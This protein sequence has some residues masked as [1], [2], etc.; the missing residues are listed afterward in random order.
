MSKRRTKFPS[1]AGPLLLAVEAFSLL[2]YL[3]LGC[4]FLC[5]P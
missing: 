2:D 5:R 3:S 1:L 4:D